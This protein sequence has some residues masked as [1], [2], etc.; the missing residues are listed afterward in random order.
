MKL[1]LML[2]LV[3]SLSSFAR[4]QDRP[5]HGRIVLE[6]EEITLSDE[7]GKEVEKRYVS[8]MGD[9]KRTIVKQVNERVR[10]ILGVKSEQEIQDKKIWKE[11]KVLRDKLMRIQ[12]LKQSRLKFLDMNG[13]VINEVQLLNIS[14][15]KRIP[16]HDSY[17]NV[18][19]STDSRQVA[20]VS[21]LGN[22]AGIISMNS[23]R[24]WDTMV[25][26][27]MT[28]EYF[29]SQGEKQWSIQGPWI[30][31][32]LHETAIF[33]ADGSRVALL[34]SELP[35]EPVME[36]H[37]NWAVIYDADGKELVRF[38]PYDQL[39]RLF[40]TK[41]GKYGYIDAVDS[42][43][44]FHVDSKALYEFPDERGNAAL[45]GFIRV[46]DSGR[47]TINKAVPGIDPQGEQNTKV[48]RE[49]SFKTVTNGQ[50]TKP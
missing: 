14:N 22:V 43:L 9:E 35:K 31:S 27:T 3:L 24:A 41:N 18:E 21:D 49:F 10:K 19:T 44:C 11:A 29:N 32:N 50:K 6:E 12:P 15:R 17:E 16:T 38:G 33:S 28:F 42:Q 26:S 37:P 36:L 46:S 39:R 20:V 13:K 8:G 48:V 30:A 2:L 47:C 4:G 40:L 1:Y 25:Y 7:S 23:Y 45:T 34:L 5:L